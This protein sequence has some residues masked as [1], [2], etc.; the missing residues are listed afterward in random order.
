ML[1]W[2]VMAPVAALFGHGGIAGTS[3]GIAKMPFI[4]FIIV[5]AFVLGLGRGGAA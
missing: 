1:R 2:G 5:A 4:G 3:A